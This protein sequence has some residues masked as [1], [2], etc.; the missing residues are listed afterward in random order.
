[1]RK[2]YDWFGGRC[3]FFAFLFTGAG[4][5]LAF[6]GHLTADYVA[7]VGA[8]QALIVAHSAKE[9]YHEREMAKLP[10]VEELL[11][12]VEEVISKI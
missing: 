11:P 4:I 10:K 2:L 3:T 9:D 6:T 1:M 7:L 12:K 5:G 8:I